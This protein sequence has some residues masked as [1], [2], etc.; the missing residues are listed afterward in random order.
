[1][2]L[3]RVTGGPY[4]VPWRNKYYHAKNEYCVYTYSYSVLELGGRM[5]TELYYY[6][7]K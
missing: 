1:M 3:L 7:N 4:Y 6:K 2:L 5:E